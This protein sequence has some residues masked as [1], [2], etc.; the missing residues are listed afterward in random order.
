M[1]VGVPFVALASGAPVIRC[2]RPQKGMRFYRLCCSAAGYLHKLAACA[3]GVSMWP[4]TCG[5]VVMTC[6]SCRV[7]RQQ[8]LCIR[9]CFQNEMR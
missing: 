5:G 7:Y 3:Y 9:V 6:E 8:R 2:F 4:A 1:D